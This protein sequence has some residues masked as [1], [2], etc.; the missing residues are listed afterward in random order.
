MFIH[1]S[2][3]E[4]LEGLRQRKSRNIEYMYREFSPLL[5]HFICRN[6]GNEQDMEDIFQDAITVLYVRSKSPSFTLD[7]NLRTY[8]MSV[9]KNLWLQ[10]LE[11]KYRLLYQAEYGVNEP[12][13]TYLTDDRDIQ[14]ERLEINRLFYKNLMKLPLDC[15]RLIELY[16]LKVPIQQIARMLNMKNTVYV[17][18]RKYTCK[19]MLR[20]KIM[21]DPEFN[22]YID[23]EGNGFYQR[24]D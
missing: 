14:E 7:C 3:E 9:C 2:D 5:R 10:R 20:K 6:S 21:N 18:T 19:N 23:Y 8:F 22:P 12:S 15:R 13:H 4:L 24:L 17:R 11:R 16:C 1:Y